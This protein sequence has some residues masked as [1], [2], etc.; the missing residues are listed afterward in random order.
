M[1][2]NER[3]QI[4]KSFECKSSLF[5]LIKTER[6]WQF[7]SVSLARFILQIITEIKPFFFSLNFSNEKKENREMN[8]QP[9]VGWRTSVTFYSQKQMPLQSSY[10]KKDF[11]KISKQKSLKYS[12][13]FKRFFRINIWLRVNTFFI[14]S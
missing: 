10:H 8:S 12:N 9:S 1:W 13:L 2:A 4:K 3:L 11:R 14:G 7:N 5:L 6:G